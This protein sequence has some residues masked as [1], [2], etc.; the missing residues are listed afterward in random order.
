MVFRSF[1]LPLH[2]AGPRA[3]AFQ[4]PELPPVFPRLGRPASGGYDESIH[5]QPTDTRRSKRIYRTRRADNRGR[6]PR[7]KTLHIPLPLEIDPN[8]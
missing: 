1:L 5:L 2:G 4:F 7:R 3:I 8:P 6:V